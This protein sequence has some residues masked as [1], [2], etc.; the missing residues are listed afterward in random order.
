MARWIASALIT[1]DGKR[2]LFRINARCYQLSQDELRA[3][4]GLPDGPPGLGITI[5][6]G[7]IKFEFPLDDQSA[8]LTVNQFQRR[9]AK[10]IVRKA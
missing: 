1:E 10:Q 3:V 7:R 4:L 5:N 2:V 6:R 9:L 8:E